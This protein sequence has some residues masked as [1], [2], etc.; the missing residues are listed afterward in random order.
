LP[1]YFPDW[2]KKVKAS[3][4][5]QFK[6]IKKLLSEFDNV[7]VL[8]AQAGEIPGINQVAS[9]QNSVPRASGGDPKPYGTA[10]LIEYN[11]TVYMDKKQFF[12]TQEEA[13]E[14]YEQSIE[15]NKKLVEEVIQNADQ[16]ETEEQAELVQHYKTTTSKL[17]N[18]L[19][20]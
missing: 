15:D 5:E 12:E 6:V 18:E 9:E 19:E 10:E 11:S 13:R 17:D 1:I 16:V 14:A 8:P 20:I 4:N 3:A 2:Q 7:I